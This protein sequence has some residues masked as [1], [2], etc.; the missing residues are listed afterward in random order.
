MVKNAFFLTLLICCVVLFWAFPSLAQDSLDKIIIKPDHSPYQLLSISG[1]NGSGQGIGLVLSGGGARGLAH[2]GVLKVL[3][4]EGI[5]IKII[6]GVSMGGVIGGLYSAGY[7]PDEIEQIVLNVNWRGLFSTSPLRNSLLITQKGLSEKSL[8]RIR[9]NNWRPV[10]PKAISSGQNL[11]QFLEKLA[12][13]GGIRSSISFDYLNPPLRIVCTDLSSGER[14]VLS[15][16]NLGEAMRATLAVPVA[17]T[18]ISI[19]DKLLVDG[20]L[21][22]PV[23]VTAIDGPRDFPIIAVNTTS[24]LIPAGGIDNIL[25][26][27]DQ[28]TTIMSMRKKKESLEL[29]DLV[30][31]PD[32]SN[33]V[34]TDFSDIPSIIFSGEKAAFAAMPRLKKLTSEYKLSDNE[35]I[36]SPIAGWEIKGLDNMPQTVFKALFVD[37]TAIS[38]DAIR[39]NLESALA[40]GYLNDAFAEVIERDTGYYIIYRLKDNARIQEVKFTGATVLSDSLMMK[41]IKTSPGMVLNN[42][43]LISDRK[44]IEDEYIRSGYNLIRV[45]TEFNKANGSLEFIVDEGRINELI[46]E[47]NKLTRDWVIKRHIPFK[48]GDIFMREKAEHGVSELYGTGLFENARYLAIP[49][50]EGVSLIARVIEKPSKMIRAGARY[51]NEYGTKAFFD[52]VDD[53]LF[54]AGQQLFL[55]TTI[56]EKRRSVALNFMADRILES[57]YTYSLSFKY[58]EFKRNFYTNHDYGGY[59]S[60]FL[61]GGELS[62]GR[63]IARFGTA[64]IV[65]KIYRY[66]WDE[67]GIKDRKKFDKGSIG[68]KSIVDTRDKISFPNAGKFHVFGLE[69]AGE[70]SGEKTAYTRFYTSIESYYKITE[71]LNFH[72]KF[73]LGLSSNSMPYFDE[74]KLGGYRNFVGLFEDEIFGNKLFLGDIEFRYDAPGP[75]F[76]HSR[77]NMGNIWNKL[78][79]IRLSELRYAV[80]A[81]VSI[82]TPIGP[83]SVWYGRTTRGLDAIYF[84]AG[85]DW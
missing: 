36:Y 32:L 34:S 31:K 30:I 28:T 2:I 46:I 22:D 48:V 51:D 43:L 35:T 21:V 50:S 58:E 72:P 4:K 1:D 79:Y 25:E 9:F 59:K 3:E 20:G 84:Y 41:L 65:G 64:W 18:P 71:K 66:R 85:H 13:R 83:I 68:F 54:G 10:I 53:N 82:S 6:A 69:F 61:H 17:F 80:G 81:G 56:G 76:I 73:A 12:L 47:G 37:S 40:T 29:A 11:S 5:N 55:T 63:Q 44:R 67:P 62:L 7:S 15:S 52:I 49:D 60:Q 45:S 39:S 77:Y 8:V 19:Q 74:F 24:D 26:V 38:S 70:L 16:G 14:V 23:P 57:Y 33:I 75:V 78:D 42:K 27:A